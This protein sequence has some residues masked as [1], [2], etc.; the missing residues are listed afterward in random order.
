MPGLPASLKAKW[1]LAVNAKSSNTLT[2]TYTGPS[3][4]YSLA[5]FK[6][7]STVEGFMHRCVA[8]RVF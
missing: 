1:Y 3:V 5:I 7:I 2:T 8:S 6:K 4:I